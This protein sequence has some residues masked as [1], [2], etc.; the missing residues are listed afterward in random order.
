[1]IVT[2]HLDTI[3]ITECS[4]E[5]VSVGLKQT[6]E[7]FQVPITNVVSFSSDTCN[8]MKGRRNGVIAKFRESQ[9]SII[10]I[11]C[12][13]HLLNLCVKS[14]IKTLPL[15]VHDLMVDV[16]YHFRNSVKRVTALQEYASFC[17]SE[18]KTVLKH[19]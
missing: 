5:G 13:C 4:A 19:C 8:V 1:M 6:L 15:K 18:Y 2:R 10:D 12:I 3:G 11:N 17:D 16:F 14:A 9:S 7:R